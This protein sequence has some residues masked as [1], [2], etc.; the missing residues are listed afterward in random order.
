MKSSHPH[1]Q[2]LFVL[3]QMGVI[4][5]VLFLFI[6][7]QILILKI[8]DPE[9]KELSIL[10]ASIFFVSCIPEPLL[11][12]QF[13]LCLFILFVGLFSIENKPIP[14]KSASSI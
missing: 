8:D 4:G 1:N 3:L 14:T 13:T 10:F 12:K 11:I 6:I 2:Y 9:I 7:Y 5:L